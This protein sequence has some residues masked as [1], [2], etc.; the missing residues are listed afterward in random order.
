MDLSVT[1]DLNGESI[2]FW[3]TPWRPSGSKVQTD[4]FSIG[5]PNFAGDRRPARIELG[6]MEIEWGD[7]GEWGYLMGC[8]QPKW[9]MNGNFMG[10]NGGL[11]V[12]GLF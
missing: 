6:K 12:S 9:W 4:L 1:F 3:L 10:F 2:L 5:F 11:N 7:D 8:N